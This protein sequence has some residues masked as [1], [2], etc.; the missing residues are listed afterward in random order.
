MTKFIFKFVTVGIV[1]LSLV[2]ACGPSE[3]VIANFIADT[4]CIKSGD[5]LQFTDLST[6]DPDSWLWTFEGAENELS[7][8]Q[9]PKVYYPEE[10]MYS[11]SLSVARHN[12]VYT[13]ERDSYIWVK[14]PL[15]YG[16][17]LHYAFNNNADDL[18]PKRNNGTLNG[19]VFVSDRHGV[20]SSAC[21]FDGVDDIISFNRDEDLGF[22]P[23]SLSFWI[24]AH[25]IS[26][27]LFGTDINFNASSGIYVSFGV[28]PE[29]YH[30]IALN[31]GN[32][33]SINPG[34]RRTFIADQELATDSLYHIVGIIKG[35]EDM[36]IYI[37]GESV[38]CFTTG[39]AS[40]YAYLSGNGVI[41]MSA[42][43][44]RYYNGILDDLRI[45]NRVLTK[46]DI[47]LLYAE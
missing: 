35:I 31:V 28:Q 27:A 22:F 17:I 1:T 44:V 9:N 45:Y 34:N 18:S 40:T 14:D 33:N 4:T 42:D 24:N 13:L 41:G 38:E 29:T 46:E 39:S 25:T 43:F 36:E 8:L 11:V 5:S 7:E 15:E 26:G 19:P 20:P 32:G 3:P 6:G 47:K 23:V 21:Y 37:N 30:R 16:L 2:H 12:F 10:G